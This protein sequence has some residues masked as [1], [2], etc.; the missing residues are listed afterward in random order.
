MRWGWRLGRAPGG[1]L[2]SDGRL[3]A[4]VSL[5]PKLTVQ[6]SR[7]VLAFSPAAR[8]VWQ[9]RIECRRAPTT[10]V[11][12]VSGRLSAGEP[13]DRSPIQPELAANGAEAQTLSQ[14]LVDLGV[15]LL[16]PRSQPTW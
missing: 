3:A 4:A 2:A 15:A 6:H 12:D 1:Q 14:Q 16:R 7:S 9:E 10:T 11:Q 13:T 8:Q 5:L